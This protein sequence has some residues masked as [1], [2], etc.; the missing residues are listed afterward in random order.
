MP[1]SLPNPS[2][3]ASK[4]DISLTEIAVGK[5]I[6]SFNPKNPNSPLTAIVNLDDIYNFDLE[7]GILLTLN[8]QKIKIFDDRYDFI[9][10]KLKAEYIEIEAISAKVKNRVGYK[11]HC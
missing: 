9:G 7:N 2:D 4:E 3:C 10:S 8:L 1:C 5:M 6:H 11:T